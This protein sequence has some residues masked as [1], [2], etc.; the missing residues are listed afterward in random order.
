MVR[1]LAIVG[2]PGSGKS[3]SASYL[4]DKGF[5]LIRFGQIIMSE[6]QKCQLPVTPK[7]EQK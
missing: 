1:T 3:I 2:M 5:P 7:N 6:V 4:K